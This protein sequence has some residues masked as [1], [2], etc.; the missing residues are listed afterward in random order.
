MKVL[1]TVNL[2]K[3]KST[4]WSKKFH[5]DFSYWAVTYILWQKLSPFPITVYAH[6]DGPGMIILKKKKDKRVT[7]KSLGQLH[8]YYTKH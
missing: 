3:E 1:K 4:A 7:G 8:K 2:G 6:P 5:P